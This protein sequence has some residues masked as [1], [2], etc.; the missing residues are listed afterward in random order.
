MTDSS[1]T[2]STFLEREVETFED[3]DTVVI[4]Q[5]RDVFIA[6]VPERVGF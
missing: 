6:E 5:G 3:T 2:D 4:T 1:L